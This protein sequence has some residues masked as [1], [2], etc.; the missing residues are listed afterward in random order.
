MTIGCETD[1]TLNDGNVERPNVTSRVNDHLLVAQCDNMGVDA[2]NHHK[3]VAPCDNIVASHDKTGN[4]TDALG[5]VAPCDN[6]GLIYSK[7]VLFLPF[8]QGGLVPCPKTLSLRVKMRSN[9]EEVPLL[10][11][12]KRQLPNRTR[13]RCLFM[14]ELQRRTFLPARNV[15]VTLLRQRCTHKGA[16]APRCGASPPS[17]PI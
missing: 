9:E 14:G 17:P 16:R 8:C 3:F 11:A 2:C 6:L 15:F 4:V 7:R 13:A 12:G 10:M 1:G 5:F